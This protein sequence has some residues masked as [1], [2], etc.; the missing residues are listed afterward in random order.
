MPIFFKLF[1]PQH[2]NG[3]LHRFGAPIFLGSAPIAAAP[4]TVLYDA[5]PDNRTEKEMQACT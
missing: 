5:R 2:P 1:H 4:C 3:R